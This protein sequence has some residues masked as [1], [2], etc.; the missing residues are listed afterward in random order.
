MCLE[1]FTNKSLIIY[2]IRKGFLIQKQILFQRLFIDQQ[3]LI[4]KVNNNKLTL[5]LQNG[6]LCIKTKQNDAYCK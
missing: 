4:S 6:F 1:G 3:H 2:L 5:N